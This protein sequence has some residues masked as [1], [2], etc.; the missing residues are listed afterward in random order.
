MVFHRDFQNKSL[1][2]IE[3]FID[4]RQL[5]TFFKPMSESNQDH[6]VDQ[7]IVQQP[8]APTLNA[9]QLAAAYQLFNLPQGPYQAFQAPPSIVEVKPARNTWEPRFVK[10]V[11]KAFGKAKADGEYDVMLP[12][13][14]KLKEVSI[15]ADLDKIKSENPSYPWI[16]VNA[17]RTKWNTLRASY[18][19][20]KR[21]QLLHTCG[22]EMEEIENEELFKHIIPNMHS[23]V[24][25]A[26]L[27]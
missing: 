17:V 2:S 8:A 16:S 10:W 7:K 18:T 26:Q 9:E 21:A 6:N 3:I 14:W 19:Q 20:A 11:L 5:G 13:D 4:W 25:P 15:K 12:A 27:V 22:G 1:W 23:T 24:T